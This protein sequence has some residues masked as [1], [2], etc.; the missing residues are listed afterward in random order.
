MSVKNKSK[1]DSNES[2][3]ETQDSNHVEVWVPKL[4]EED[5]H[6]WIPGYDFFIALFMRFDASFIVIL[7]LENIN[8]GL[9]ILVT[10]S[11]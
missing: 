9:W 7:I 2:S 11:V 4:I 6:P 1:K 3:E 8:F 5:K 10:L